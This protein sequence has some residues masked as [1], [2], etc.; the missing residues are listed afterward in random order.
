MFIGIGAIDQISWLTVARI[1]ETCAEW[2]DAS[3]VIASQGGFSW[4]YLDR[5]S[6]HADPV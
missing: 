4:L 6:A 2:F 3:R 1:T 5:A